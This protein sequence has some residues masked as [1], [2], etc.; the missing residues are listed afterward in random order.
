MIKHFMMVTFLVLLSAINPVYAADQPAETEVPVIHIKASR[1]VFSPTQITIKK[2]Q[3]VLLE[4]EA[5]DHQHGFS[6]PELGVR[7]DVTP[8]QKNLLKITATKTGKL[9]FYCDIFCGSGHEQMEGEILVE[10]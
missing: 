6:I 5:T 10:S 7:T 9:V 3:T 2:G 4:I 1:F 8:G